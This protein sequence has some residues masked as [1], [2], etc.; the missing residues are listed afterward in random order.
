M[1]NVF[2]RCRALGIRHR[3][4]AD[5]A[6]VD[7]GYVTCCAGGRKPT[8]RKVRDAAEALLRERLAHQ[9]ETLGTVMAATLQEQ[10]AGGGV[11]GE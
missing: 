8:S 10:G 6:G 4:I 11:D 7:R 5:R 2:A 3:D 9:V 1:T